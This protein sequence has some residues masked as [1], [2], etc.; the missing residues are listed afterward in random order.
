MNSILG[1]ISTLRKG[2]PLVIDYKNSNRYRLVAIEP[3]GTKTAYYFTSPIYNNRTRKAVDMK[4]HSKGG[5]AYITGSNANISVGNNIRMEN[6]KGYCVISL[7]EQISRISET[8]VVYANNRL[9]PTTNGIAI[10]SFCSEGNGC[11]FSVEIS[12]PFLEVRANVKC[13]ALMSE[14]FRPFVS[15]SCV[16]TSDANGNVIAPA[17]ISYQKITDRKYTVSVVPC[18]SLGKSVLIET[19]LYEPKLFQDTTVESKNAK[20]NNAF[21]SIGF[22][23][24]TKEFGEQWLYS[25]PDFTKMSELNDKKILRAVLHLPKLSTGAVELTSSKVAAR[26]CSFGSTWDNKIAETGALNESQITDHYIDLNLMPMLTDTQGRLQRSEGFI[27][28]AK[29]KN[30][31]FSVVAT[32]DN[33]FSPQILEINYR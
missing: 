20:V 27:L 24:S 18:S 21:G 1:E 15:F 32:G 19:N 29:K 10:R 14:R 4:F 5:V 28:K 3:N 30:S 13:V 6:S 31:G 12:K 25:K 8:E 33:Y 16:G 9:Y 2:A 23:G 26:F 11:T 22:I 7:S 17:K